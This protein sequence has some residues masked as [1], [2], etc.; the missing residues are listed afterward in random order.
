MITFADPASQKRW[1][2]MTMGEDYWLDLLPLGV[3]E[4]Y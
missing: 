4:G 2:S 1:I 3:S